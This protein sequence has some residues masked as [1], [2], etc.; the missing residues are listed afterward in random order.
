MY[1]AQQL[2]KKF[3]LKMKSLSLAPF[4]VLAVFKLKISFSERYIK[5]LRNNFHNQLSNLLAP[6]SSSP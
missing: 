3:A 4:V 2:G 6:L 5:K 1:I